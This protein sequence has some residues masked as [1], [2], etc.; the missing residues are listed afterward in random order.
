MPKPVLLL[1]VCLFTLSVI[2]LGS[3]TVGQEKQSSQADLQKKP[4]SQSNQDTQSGGPVRD[5]WPRF[6]G[7]DFQNAASVPDIDWTAQ[8]DLAWSK[9]LGDGYGLG[10]IVGGN[11]FHLDAVESGTKERLRCIDMTTGE[12]KWAKLTDVVYRDLLGYETGARSCPTIADDHIYAMGVAGRLTCRQIGDGSEVWSLDT[13]EQYGVVQNFFG[14]GG[15]PLV[16]GDKLIVMIG[17]SPPE[18]QKIAPGRLSRV[19]PNGSALVALDRKSGKELW[20]AGDDLA[21]YSSPRTIQIGN[22]TLVLIFARDHLLA[23]DSDTGNV[24]WKFHHRAEIQESVNAMVPIV[25]GNLIFISECYQV[26]SVLLKATETDCEVV[27]QDPDRNRRAQAMRI[28]WSNPAFID[29]H[30]FG[31]SGRNAPDSD[32]RCIEFATGK[33]K[34]TDPRRIRSAV[35]QAGDHMIV[36][37]ERGFTQVMKPNT[38]KMEVIAEWNLQLADGKRPALNYPCWAA[39][40][41]V[42]DKV[43]IRGDENLVCLKLKSNE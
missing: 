37:E 21:S 33:L 16:V 18:D 3:I 15:A 34:W 12:T 24:N 31:C 13:N 35:T 25:D 14:V 2:L 41:I 19:S 10:P 8:P 4:D 1:S 43:L 7:N 40:V 5:S 38:Q 29:G 6:L 26:G 36:L 9:K 39:P 42:G 20:K 22:K 17:G 32:F 27:W 11:Y 30:L 28:H 23:I